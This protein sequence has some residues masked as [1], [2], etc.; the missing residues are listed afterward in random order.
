VIVAFDDAWLRD[1]VL[2]A[3]HTGPSLRAVALAS[4]A[5]AG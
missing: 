5:A 1:D 2:A 4:A 3:E